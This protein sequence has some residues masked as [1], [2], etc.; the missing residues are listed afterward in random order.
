[1]LK[2]AVAAGLIATFCSSP[3][4]AQEAVDPAVIEQ[5]KSLYEQNCA[6][7]HQ[8]GGEGFAPVFP[9]LANNAKLEDLD[10]IVTNIHEGKGAMPPF[11]QLSAE[12]ISA[13]ATYIR[14]SFGNT[15]GAASTEDVSAILEGGTA[16]AAHEATEPETTDV[17]GTGQVSIW[18][19]PGVYTEEQA[20][21]GM[22]INE[23]SCANCHGLRMDGASLDPDKP[24]TPPI[25]R[26]RFLR[27]WS[28]QSLAVLYEYI[29]G[30]MPKNNP[31]ALSDQ[32]YADVI[33]AMLATTGTPAG[34]NELPGD[35]AALT[36]ILL[37]QKP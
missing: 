36:E 28:G 26:D 32:Q 27:K 6:S 37:E 22:A 3:A 14:N 13:I 23:G 7:C 24:S 35:P 30:T 18:D 33:A 31:G 15:F 8:A 21:R 4:L 12:Q 17:A 5:G 16:A 34:E 29:R 11:P 9:A 25:A 10:L 20:A 19:E 2:R 1:M